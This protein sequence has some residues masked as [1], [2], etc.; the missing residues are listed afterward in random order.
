MKVL[1]DGSVVL[2]RMACVVLPWSRVT[3]PSARELAT[4]EAMVKFLVSD[5]G[6]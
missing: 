4:S 2:S 3:R 6:E 5:S 1:V